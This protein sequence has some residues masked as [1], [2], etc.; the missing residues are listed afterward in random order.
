MAI[1]KTEEWMAKE[2]TNL[3]MM[4]KK[5]NENDNGEG[6]EQRAGGSR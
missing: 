3:E 1:D 4:S 2:H 6:P 5:M